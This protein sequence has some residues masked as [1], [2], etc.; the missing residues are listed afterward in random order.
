MQKLLQAA[1]GFETKLRIVVI[2]QS[3]TND[4]LS[5]EDNP[6]VSCLRQP[7]M[8]ASRARNIGLAIAL[9]C[10]DRVIFADCRTIYTRSFC[11]NVFTDQAK[12]AAVWVGNVEWQNIAGAEHLQKGERQSLRAID[13]AYSG[14]L[15]RCVFSADVL[16]GHHFDESIGPGAGGRIIAGEDSLFMAS[17]I[18]E[19]R[20]ESVTFC[21]SAM[22]TRLERPRMAAK[23][24]AY[25]F[26][27]GVRLGRMLRLPFSTSQRFR[28]AWLGAG[29]LVR[30]AMWLAARDQAKRSR[31]RDRLRGLVDGLCMQ[32]A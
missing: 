20:L 22:V 3:S 11:Y 5:F 8:G 32:P 9:T 31:G 15:W 2:F 1:T 21:P 29:F 7:P 13:I 17:V 18:V 4:A 10:C 25:A 27:A 19:N 12:A 26:G 30:T 14:F 28:L 16:R 6:M 24:A 23:Q